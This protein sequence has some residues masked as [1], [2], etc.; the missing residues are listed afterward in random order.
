MK[1]RT[2]RELSGE[3]WA[4]IEHDM[5]EKKSAGA[6]LYDG[7]SNDA[8]IAV[9]ELITGVLARHVGSVITNDSDIPAV[10]LPKRN[11]P[12]S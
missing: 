11:L 3:I 12:P 7:F 8:F 6:T 1:Q 9:L 10:P 5:L 4:E 2:V